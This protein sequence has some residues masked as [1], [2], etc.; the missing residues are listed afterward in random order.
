MRCSTASPE[1]GHIRG[2]HYL[3]SY[4]ALLFAPRPI[5]ALCTWPSSCGPL[6]R[7]CI[8]GT[9]VSIGDGGCSEVRALP[10][11]KQ[12]DW[13][14]PAGIGH[15]YANIDFFAGSG[16]SRPPRLCHTPLEEPSTVT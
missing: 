7:Q 16:W 2:A 11:V 15:L 13:R 10:P 9:R 12:S 6:P 14:H 5:V 4:D 1:G 3:L 8:E